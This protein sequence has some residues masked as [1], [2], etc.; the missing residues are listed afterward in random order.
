GR[1]VLVKFAGGE[2][3]PVT[4]QWQD[5]LFAESVALEAVRAAGLEAANAALFDLGGGRFLEGER[6]DRVGALG[7]Q[8]LVSLF[9]LGAEYLGH[10]DGWTRAS[11]DLLEMQRLDAADARRLRWLDAFGQLIGN[12]DRHFANI[13]F[14]VAGDGTLQLAP[15]YDMLPML[16]APHS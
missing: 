4:E 1:H 9:V 8:A 15:I 13:S 14:F 3:G 2:P 7:R 10:L 16:L 6:F 5:L 11:H 12:T